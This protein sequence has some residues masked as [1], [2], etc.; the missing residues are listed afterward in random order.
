[1]IPKITQKWRKHQI[2]KNKEFIEQKRM[3]FPILL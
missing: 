2:R 3:G 1:M